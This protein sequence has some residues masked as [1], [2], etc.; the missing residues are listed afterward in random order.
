MK[1]L[2]PRRARAGR[3]ARCRHQQDRLPDRAA[4]RRTRRSDVLRRRSHG[5]E[6]LGF[7]H[8]A[9][10]G[11]KAGGVVDLVAG[12]GMRCA[13]PSICAERTAEVQL[14]SVRGLALGRPARQRTFRRRVELAGRRCRKATSPA[15]WRPAAGIRCATGRAV[16]HSLPIG[17]SLDAAT[18]I[19][20]PRGMLGAPLRR[21]HAHGD[22]RRRA[23]AQPDA[24]G[25]ALPSRR[26]GD[27]GGALC[28]RACRCSPTTRPISAPP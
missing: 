1:P 20:D 16:L 19:R 18:G 25:R 7:G 15:C 22:G 8:T 6:V 2:S 14:E 9:A 5:V 12:R 24:R 27:G 11:I 23:G 28:R 26:R 17:Y 13:R 21:R 3:R 4:R 10:R